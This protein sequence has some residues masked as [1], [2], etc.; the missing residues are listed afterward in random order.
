MSGAKHSFADNRTVTVADA[1][2]LFADYDG[3]RHAIAIASGYFNVGGFALIADALERA[4]GT[5]IL[6]GAEP[7]DWDE[8]DR[9][10]EDDPRSGVKRLEAGLEAGRDRLPFKRFT[11]TDLRRLIAF[12]ERPTTQVR[13]YRRKFL[14]G[15][16]FIFGSQGAVIAGSANFTRAGLL[17]NYELNLGQFDPDKVERVHRWF[18]ELWDEGEAYDLAAIYTAR[19]TEYEPYR[20]YLRMLYEFYGEDAGAAEKEM[21]GLATLR[22]TEFQRLGA[23]RARRVLDEWGGAMVADAVGLG[24][25]FVA[26]DVIRDYSGRGEHVFV[27]CPAA[28]RPM[29]QRFAARNQLP[30][31]ISSYTELANDASV[32]EGTG[33]ALKG[34]APKFFRLVVADE[35]HALRSPD[36]GYYRAVRKLM[37]QSPEARLLLLTATPVNNAIRDLYYEI[38]LFARSDARFARIG[39]PSLTELFRKV[40][41]TAPDDLEPSLLFPLLDAVAVRRTRAFIKREFPG[42][43]IDGPDGEPQPIAF[44]KADLH[45]IGYDLDALRP[46]L[47][48]RVADAIENG[49]KLARY[50]TSTYALDPDEFEGDAVR[51]EVLSGL[52]RSQMLKRFESSIE[53]FRRT[54]R[55]ISDGTRALARFVRE[56]R[57]VPLGRF[58]PLELESENLDDAVDFDADDF[59]DAAR[60]DTDRLLVDLE[61]DAALLDAL[62]EEIAAIGPGDDPKVGALLDLL[63]RAGEQTGDARKT[64]VFT[65][66]TDTVDYLRAY[67]DNRIARNPR[68]AY[69][70]ERAAFVSTDLSADQRVDCAVAFA[71]RS[72]RPDAPETPDRYDLLVATDVLAE[73]QN[74]QQCGRVVNYDLPWNPMRV[75]QRNGRIDRI[76]STFEHIEVAC[77]FPDRELDRLLRLEQ[78]LRVKIAYANAALGAEEML[79][80]VEGAERIFEDR[81]KS[82]ERLEHEDA[83]ILDELEPDDAFA[84]EAFREELRRAL[85]REAREQYERLPWGVGSGFLGAGPTRII[86]LARIGRTNALVSIRLDGPVD[87]NQLHNLQAARCLPET[88]RV[89]SDELHEHALDGWERCR[90]VLLAQYNERRDPAEVPRLPKPQREAIAL[91][92]PVGTEEAHAACEALSIPWPRDVEHALRAI[93][94]DEHSAD[95]A[96]IAGVLSLVSERGLTAGEPEDLPEINEDDIALVCYQVVSE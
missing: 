77:F 66:F 4:P 6:L 82:I 45:R 41:R 79:P 7:K 27:V 22:L 73:G 81:R 49:L 13:I 3:D 36:T 31:V 37:R 52:L 87:T 2:N 95:S 92:Q 76:G 10:L 19:F 68:L 56:E 93:V 21:P 16:A 58:D 14:H 44:P 35:A 75:A 48:A 40:E 54:L 55:R 59:A 34:L 64:L 78:R 85:L 88:D 91:L 9:T 17:H 18:E 25:T 47:F 28:L 71:P 32:G 69:L 53:A 70:R 84:G 74:L 89:M 61:A 42:A 23:A 63:V 12:L 39:I 1:V 51:Q 29:W 86:Y 90:S 94:R 33:D 67:I 8:R 96:K 72:M 50:L 43:T 46:G 26:A 83:A 60:F 24:K 57:R 20:M 15:K 65:S 30:I 62:R 11:E 38:A 5:R 80:G